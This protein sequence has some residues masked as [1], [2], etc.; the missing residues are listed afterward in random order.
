MDAEKYEEKI[1]ELQ[2][3]YDDL[4]MEKNKFVAEVDRLQDVIAD[5]TYLVENS[6]RK[7]I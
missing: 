2:E 5:I 1:E 6:K 7:N 3:K 4:E